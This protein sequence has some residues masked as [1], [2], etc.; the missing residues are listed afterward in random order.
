MAQIVNHEPS[1]WLL[2]SLI[3][4]IRTIQLS[5]FEDRITFRDVPRLTNCIPF[6]HTGRASIA[7]RGGKGRDEQLTEIFDHLSP[8]QYAFLTGVLAILADH[9]E[10]ALTRSCEMVIERFGRGHAG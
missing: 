5:N 1:K 3:T 7:R 8:A 10:E 4:E 9:G 6:E 2:F